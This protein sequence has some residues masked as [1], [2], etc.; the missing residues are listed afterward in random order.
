M[1]FLPKMPTVLLYVP[2]SPTC[3]RACTAGC[4]KDVRSRRPFGRVGLVH[5]AIR[6]KGAE[7][8]AAMEHIASRQQGTPVGREKHVV[9]VGA[10]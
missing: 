7:F 3:S 2:A 6:R 9:G 5:G 4:A 10:R 8:R 1:L